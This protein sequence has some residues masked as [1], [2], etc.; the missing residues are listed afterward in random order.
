MKNFWESLHVSMTCAKVNLH[1]WFWES[2]SN[3]YIHHW[4]KQQLEANLL[5]PAFP[6]IFLSTLTNLRQWFAFSIIFSVYLSAMLAKT[7]AVMLTFIATKP[8]N[9]LK[10]WLGKNLP[11]AIVLCDFVIHV[12]G[13]EWNFSSNYTQN[14]GSL[15]SQTYRQNIDRLRTLLS[16][17][18]IYFNILCELSP[19]LF[20]DWTVDTAM[21]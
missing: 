18:S 11:M 7:L 9:R 15:L 21:Q 4:W 1:F 17:S 8:G 13:L 19:S 3:S 14:Q 5:P 12:H 20:P 6:L 10:T 16:A 2:S